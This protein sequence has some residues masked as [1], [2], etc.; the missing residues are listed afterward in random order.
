M[1]HL[2]RNLAPT[3]GG[4]DFSSVPRQ[5]IQAKKKVTVP[6]SQ[7]E[8]TVR[9]NSLLG[10]KLNIKDWDFDPMRVIKILTG[11]EANK[12]EYSGLV[13]HPTN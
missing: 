5:P 10:E 9:D 8:H 2:P 12:D 4:F 6:Y 13:S 3:S 7:A 11:K 1:P